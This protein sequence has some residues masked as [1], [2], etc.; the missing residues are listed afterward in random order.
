MFPRFKLPLLDE[1]A[2]EFLFMLEGVGG[3]D[4]FLPSFSFEVLTGFSKDNS[5][6]CLTPGNKGNMSLGLRTLPALSE[7][8]QYVMAK[9]S[10]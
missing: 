10:R 7:V 4:P 1:L 9:Y 6:G 2:R 8:L 3:A 5:S